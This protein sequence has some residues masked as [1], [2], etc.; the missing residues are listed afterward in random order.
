MQWRIYGRFT[1]KEQAKE[2]RNKGIC[3]TRD[4]C[5]DRM[6]INSKRNDLNEKK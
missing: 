4:C 1:R 5:S 6:G 2:A 3:G